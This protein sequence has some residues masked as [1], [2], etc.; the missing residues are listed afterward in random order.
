M[1]FFIE[2]QAFLLSLDS[3]PRPPPFYPLPI[4]NKMLKKCCSYMEVFRVMI[5][6]TE[7]YLFCRR[8][9]K[10]CH[11]CRFCCSLPLCTFNTTKGI[12]LRSSFETTLFW[13]DSLNKN[14]DKHV[15]KGLEDKNSSH[16][17]TNALCKS[18]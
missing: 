6:Y 7:S 10:N 2:D 3:A 4:I 8:D 11:R 13:L 1:E 12:Y 14:Y 5:S 18:I 16:R 17:T 15:K 9:K